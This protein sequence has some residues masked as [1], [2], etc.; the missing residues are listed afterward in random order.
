MHKVLLV[1]DQVLFVESLRSVIENRAPDFTVCGVVYDGDAAVSAVPR[2]E[3]DLVLM[4]VRMP[5]TDGVQATRTIL[6]HSESVRVVMLTTYA[7]DEYVHQ[8]IRHGAVGYLLK[9][10]PPDALLSC[11]RSALSG[12]LIIPSRFAGRVLAGSVSGWGDHSHPSAGSSR[13]H[14]AESGAYGPIDPPDWL[15]ELSRKERMILRLIVEGYNNEEI[16]G[17]VFLAEQTVKNYVSRIYARA[18]VD[19]RAH[20]MREGRRLLNYL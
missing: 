9:D 8:A 15:F 20:L 5:G 3:P 1:D 19:S 17:R 11:M 13:D 2:L 14:S 10:M 18:G 7:E 4:D 16:A 6:Q 12:Q